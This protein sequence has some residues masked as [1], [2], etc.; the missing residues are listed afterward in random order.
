MEYSQGEMNGKRFE[1][2][3]FEFRGDLSKAT[4]PYVRAQIKPQVNFWLHKW[5]KRI[6]QILGL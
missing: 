6:T 1:N 3:H 4:N 2:N 5:K